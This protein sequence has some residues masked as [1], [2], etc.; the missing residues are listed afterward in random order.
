MS[1]ANR[2]FLIGPMGAGKSTVGR[3][4]ARALGREFL[5]SDRVIEERTGARIPWIFEVE[6]EAGFR[7]RERAVLADLTARPG[8]VLAT[9]G[10]AILDPTNRAHLAERGTVIYLKTSLEQQLRRVARDPNR[11]LVQVADPRAKLQSLMAER[12]PLYE[13]VAH[14]VIRTDAQGPHHVVR[15]L[16]ARLPEAARPTRASTSRPAQS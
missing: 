7:G 16:L 6:G 12:G 9:G 8:I 5:D 4:L 2:Y 3:R 11:P 15:R 1:D 13:S 10:G 14:H